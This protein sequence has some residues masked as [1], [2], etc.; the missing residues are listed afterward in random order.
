MYRKI[1]TALGFLVLASIGLLGCQ[2]TETSISTPS[3]TTSPAV[4]PSSKP[5]P[6]EP[7]S[8]DINWSIGDTVVAATITR[9][10][11]AKVHPAIVFIPGSGPTDRDWNSSLLTGTN[12]SARLL[13][14][15]LV[16]NGFV[17]IRYDK[18]FTGPNAQKNLPFL[19]G[20]ISMESHM[21]EVAGAVDHLRS[22]S[23]VD[24]GQ[25]YA[26]ANSEGTIH[27]MNYQIRQKN[28][29]AGLV[30]LAPPGRNM[31]ALMHSQIEAQ[32]ASLPDAQT[33]MAGY[34]KLVADFVA[35]K[36][37]ISD[38][39][40]PEGI[41]TLIQSFYAPVNLPFTRELF[42]TDPA[43]LLGQ[44]TTPV[45]LVIGKKDVQVD[46]Q[47]DGAL[48]ETAAKLHQNVTFFY[49]ENAN[50]VLKNEPRPRSALTG[51]DSLTYNASDRV[52]DPEALKI[53][54]DWL[55]SQTTRK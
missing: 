9:P 16:K 7:V 11:D 44:V 35:G 8:E 43:V 30:L 19:I 46:W 28:A 29:F 15:D 49:P 17:T 21:E 54:Q 14:N 36:A 18:R 10:D 3:T 2:A 5:A 33:I 55:A 32:V 20:K 26:V 53:V 52:L 6:I 39:A 12:G 31:V 1:S 37:F 38:P 41:N 25:I 34:E 24:P 40:V 22:R 27:A 47:A 50:H 4:T 13:A 42:T 51:A 48:L 23:D 45:L